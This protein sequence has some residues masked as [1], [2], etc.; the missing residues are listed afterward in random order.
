M[1]RSGRRERLAFFDDVHS[2]QLERL[3]ASVPRIMPDSAGNDEPVPR[4]DMQRGLTFHQHV[5]LAR[6]NVADLIAWMSVPPSRC[7]WRGLD[8]GDYAF[9]TG[10]RYIRALHQSP[11]DSRVLRQYRDHEQRG[12]NQR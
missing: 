4:F 5:A 9:T 7:S 2:Y 10:N 11:L 3:C 8:A 12:Q 1:L 6:E